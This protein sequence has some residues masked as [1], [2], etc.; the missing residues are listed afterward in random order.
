MSE[1][2]VYIAQLLCPE[3]HAILA[4]AEEFDTLAEA[5]EV[6]GK[7]VEEVRASAML[8]P[9]CG[10]CNSRNLSVEVRP[11]IFRTIEEARPELHASEAAQLATSQFLK[12]T[13][14]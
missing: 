2:K 13:K 11:T 14:N 3:R 6:L 4:F 9:W 7:R 8:N 10:L 12:A 1:R 5:E